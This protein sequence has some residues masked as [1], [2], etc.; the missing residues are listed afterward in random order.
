V[1]S[2]AV[3]SPMNR[4]ASVSLAEHHRGAL[5]THERNALIGLNMRRSQR[6]VADTIGVRA[7]FAVLF[8][9]GRE[10]IF[11]DGF[12]HN[13][14]AVTMPPHSPKLIAPITPTLS[15]IISRPTSFMLQP[16]LS[17]IVLSDQEVDSFN[18]AVQVYAREEIFY[19][20]H[21]PTL[22]DAFRSGKHLAYADPDNPM[23]NLIRAIPGIP[24]RDTS[25]DRFR[26]DRT[27]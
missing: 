8:S 5:P 11:G 17:T 1:V 16:R 25:F 26:R 23:D 6:V 18:H 3:R 27:R 2:L 22:E 19:R 10:F 14:R 15:V 21:R 20:S 9:A 4:E 24:P 13:V 12:F 7:K